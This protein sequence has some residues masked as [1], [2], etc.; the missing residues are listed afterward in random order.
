[1]EVPWVVVVVVEV[2]DSGIRRMIHCV[3]VGI[4]KVLGERFND[5][6]ADG[7]GREVEAWTPVDDVL[8]IVGS[9]LVGGDVLK[10]TR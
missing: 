7:I 3:G 6:L 4:R 1:M 8:E 2:D 5:C 10:M 9:S